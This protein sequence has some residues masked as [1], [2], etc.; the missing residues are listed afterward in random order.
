M[1]T[2]DVIYEF[3]GLWSCDS[4]CRI[5]IY[6][7]AGPQS[8]MTVVL[9]TELEDNEGTSVTNYA[10]HI[11]SEIMRLY[12]IAPHSLLWIEHYEYR[13]VKLRH[14]ETGRLTAQFAEHFDRV[15]FNE[16]DSRTGNLKRP[17]W[18]RFTK[19]TVEQWIGESVSSPE[20]E[21]WERVGMPEGTVHP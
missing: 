5:R 7:G 8:G 17:A 1:L 12:N 10:E 15:I 20:C 9:C 18:V 6:E 3:K 21:T 4:K 19:Q 2:Q 13:G 14:H 11:A 16:V